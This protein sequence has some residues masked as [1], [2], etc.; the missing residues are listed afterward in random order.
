MSALTK[1]PVFMFANAIVTLNGV[2]ALMKDRFSVRSG[3]ATYVRWI[4]AD[5]P[6]L[7]NLV[8][9]ILFLLGICPM[10][11]GL[12]EPAMICSPLVS[13]CPKQKLMKLFVDVREGFRF[14]S[15]PFLA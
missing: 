8:E 1:K 12:Q 5:A 11:I 6:G 10:G 7:L 13:S 15:E 9:G 14:A 4:T 2:L 3:Q